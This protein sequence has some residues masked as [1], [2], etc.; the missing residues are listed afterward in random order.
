LI[1]HNWNVHI[2]N[3]SEKLTSINYTLLTLKTIVDQPTLLLVYFG[4]FLS[5]IS[6]GIT[7]WGGRDRIFKKIFVHQ[8]RA[9]RRISI[10]Q[11]KKQ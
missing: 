11:K 1:I 9:V 2:K 5:R 4:L 10:E 8:K 3:I 7:F 6:Y